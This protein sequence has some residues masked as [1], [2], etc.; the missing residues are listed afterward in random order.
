MG[1]LQKIPYVGKATEASLK[2][3]GY[4]TIASLKGADP[5][6]MYQKECEI[7]KQPIDRC[8]LYMY[9]MV[10]YYANNENPDQD[11]LKWWYWKDK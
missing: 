9:R 8:Q 1:E 2:L 4:D 7:R 5:E 3:I 6:K 11:K 10:V